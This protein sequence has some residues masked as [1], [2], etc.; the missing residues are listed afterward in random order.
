MVLNPDSKM[1]NVW[2]FLVGGISTKAYLK[3]HPNL[4]IFSREI[5]L[6][7]PHFDLHPSSYALTLDD[8]TTDTQSHMLLG[9]KK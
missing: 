8:Q 4:L 9:Y 3:A 5:F 2:D 7:F 6:F 1:W